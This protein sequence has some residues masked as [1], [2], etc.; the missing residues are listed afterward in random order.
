[1]LAATE[2]ITTVPKWAEE[3]S[4]K[5]ISWAKMAPA[6]GELKVAEMPAAAPQATSPRMR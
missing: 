4:P 5:M 3:N 1:M 6:M 2:L